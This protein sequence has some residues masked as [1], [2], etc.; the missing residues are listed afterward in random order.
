LRVE[1]VGGDAGAAGVR[2][3]GIEDGGLVTILEVAAS[4]ALE[5]G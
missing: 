1:R 5:L 2:S 3:A 4:D